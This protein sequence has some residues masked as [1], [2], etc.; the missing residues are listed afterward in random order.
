MN[1][2]LNNH[3][4]KPKAV[5]KWEIEEWQEI[6]AASI[7][8]PEQLAQHFKINVEEVRKVHRKYP[9]RINPYYLSLIEKPGDP[10]WKMAV[11]D[12]AELC[13]PG[14]ED[15]LGEEHDSPVPGIT[16]RYPDRVLFYTTHACA[17]YC[18][19]CT[20]KRKVAD[21]NSVDEIRIQSG[22][23]YIRKHPEVR[24]VVVSGGDP[25][26]HKTGRLEAIISRIRAI[27]HVEIIRIGSRIP[28]TL[29]QRITPELCDMLKKYHP[30]YL[31]TH[32][33][34]PREITRQSARACAMLADA[35]IPLGNQSVLLRGVNDDPA[36]MKRLVQRL[37]MIRVKPYLIF[38]P[39]VVKGTSHF[40]TT[41]QQGFA[42]ISALRGHTSGLA[43]PHYVI[44]APG[45]GGKIAIMPNPVMSLSDNHVTVKNYEGNLYTYENIQPGEERSFVPHGP[46]PHEVDAG[47]GVAAMSP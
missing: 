30:I 39:D 1:G 13:G 21:P 20:R 27:P 28:V 16:H 3:S 22:L 47:L 19:F 7:T 33:N 45:G 38:H 36:V 42:V 35:G 43:V 11:P 44:D 23:D 9:L 40:W 29:P 37:L 32:F 14:I 10:I 26:L 15:A 4:Q 6:L 25:L 34:H 17:M 46:G 24:D 12:G 8:T 31:N 5:P 2:I 41:I 18:R